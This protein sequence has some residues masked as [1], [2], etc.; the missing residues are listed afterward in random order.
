MS[1][2]RLHLILAS[3]LSSASFGAATITS[4]STL[5]TFAA[6]DG[7]YSILWEGN[8]LL[9]AGSVTSF[10]YY[11][12]A[13]GSIR[14]LLIEQTGSTYNVIGVGTPFTA[15]SAGLQNNVSFNLASGTSS[16]NTG[17]GSKYFF[18]FSPVGAAAL[19][20][21][22]NVNS[23]VGA[24]PSGLGHALNF[25]LGELSTTGPVT[26]GGALNG[27]QGRLYGISVT[28]T[29]SGFLTSVGNPLVNRQF[30]DTSAGFGFVKTDASFSATGEL[31]RWEFFSDDAS[32]RNITPV[33]YKAGSVAG[34][35]D[36]VGVGTS[37]NITSRGFMEFDFG[38]TSGSNV[39]TAAG[40]FYAGWIDSKTDGTG[41]LNGVIPYTP[42]GG[43][44]AFFP[45]PAGG[46]VA[47]S[48]IVPGGT[49]PRAYSVNFL[50]VPEPATASL[51]LLAVA[52]LL[53]RRR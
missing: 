27:A 46:P 20:V 7:N 51:G 12:R 17:T 33:L 11:S 45:I 34:T 15:S 47:G 32:G 52:A 48:N 31:A 35:Y 49:D 13:A 50:V 9:G 21:G 4:G 53:R 40:N 25:I 3:L 30:V 43:T 23:E 10:S 44:V 28:T 37:R 41:A 36:V 2:F 39:I 38:L 16:F 42:S 18:A 26:W 24:N 22:Y 8:T 6:N 1:I 14:P 5:G 29:Q 19:Q